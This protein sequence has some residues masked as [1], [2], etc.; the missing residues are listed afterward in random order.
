MGDPGAKLNIPQEEFVGY[1]GSPTPHHKH[2]WV[3]DPLWRASQTPALPALVHPGSKDGCRELAG[4][5]PSPSPGAKS[6]GELSQPRP[7]RALKAAE[8]S[9]ALGTSLSPADKRAGTR[10]EWR[11]AGEQLF[12]VPGAASQSQGAEL[13]AHKTREPRPKLP[14][15]TGDLVGTHCGLL[16]ATVTVVLAA[17]L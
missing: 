10:Q 2:G 14:E 17:H 9:P 15:G 3:A 1:K 6:S 12:P 11:M 8:S 7:S 4:H 16:R 5:W 13:T